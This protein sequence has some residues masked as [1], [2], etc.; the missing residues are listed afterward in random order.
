MN[1]QN[2]QAILGAVFIVLLSG[3]VFNLNSITGNAVLATESGI[4]V[5][6]HVLKAGEDLNVKI[7][8][9]EEGV[10]NTFNIERNGKRI[11]KS[12]ELCKEHRCYGDIETVYPTSKHLESGIYTISSYDYTNSKIIEA[13][14]T[15]E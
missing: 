7:A 13:D 8:V 14:F 2:H 11:G 15:I 4:Y 1:L 5:S 9:G 10:S 12:A 3:I 6:P